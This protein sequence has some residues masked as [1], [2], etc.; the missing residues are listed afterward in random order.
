MTSLSDLLHRIEGAEGGS[1][2]LDSEIHLAVTGQRPIKTR[3]GPEEPG[4]L[5]LRAYTTSIDAALALVEAKLPGGIL[6]LSGNQEGGWEAGLHWSD[7]TGPHHSRGEIDLVFPNP[8]LATVAAL[9]RSL[10]SDEAKT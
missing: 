4:G 8:A 3:F 5:V 2:E 7:A 1:R 10:I 9:L 6:V